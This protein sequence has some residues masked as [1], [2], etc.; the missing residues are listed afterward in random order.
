MV[1]NN[2]I[3]MFEQQGDFFEGLL[4][5][6]YCGLKVILIYHNGLYTKIKCAKNVE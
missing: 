3:V 6:D 1:E 5:C 2:K 4:T